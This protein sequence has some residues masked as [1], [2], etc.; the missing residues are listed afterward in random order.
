MKKQH[1]C[2]KK[3]NICKV[4]YTEED[5]VDHGGVSALILGNHSVPRMLIF[6]HK[7]LQKWTIPVGKIKHNEVS[8]HALIRECKEEVDIDVVNWT[9]IK[10]FRQQFEREGRMVNIYQYLY[11]VAPTEYKG[12]AR[13]A[14]PDKHS[15]MKW[16][17]YKEA[18]AINPKEMTH[19]M[20]IAINE[21]KRITGL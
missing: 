5:L 20:L 15:D 16:V 4:N 14:E 17:T 8:Y 10:M 9:N 2:N 7:K 18:L 21:L 11:L 12:E 1:N 13:N 6:W 3:E 19:V